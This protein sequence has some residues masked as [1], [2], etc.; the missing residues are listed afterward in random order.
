V[1]ITARWYGDGLTNGTTVGTSTA[2]TGDTAFNQ[3]TSGPFTVSTT[4]PRSPRIKVDQQASTVAQATWTSTAIGSH[5]QHAV[6]AYCEFTAWPSA[7]APLLAGYGSS[8][9]ALQWRITITAAGA[10]R[11][12]NASAATVA[13]SS[14]TT[15]PLNQPLRFEV[16]VNSGAATVHVYAVGSTTPLVSLSGTVG[17]TAVDA[18]R[19]GNSQTSPTWPTWYVDDIA[20]ADAATEIGP[21][22]LSADLVAAG[23]LTATPTLGLALAADLVA[24]GDLSAD[25][26]API[27]LSASLVAE[28]TLVAAPRLNLALSASLAAEATLS[29]DIGAVPLSVLRSGAWAPVTPY[30]LTGGSWQS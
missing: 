14:P 29:A 2:G 5:T 13:D 6:R 21:M 22:E 18:V 9:T 27:P 19:V 26:T 16:V 24:S 28:A 1:A 25:L 23:T 4:G 20:A 10:V 8:N 12:L 30:Y 15:L 7:S 3:V 17:S 11:I